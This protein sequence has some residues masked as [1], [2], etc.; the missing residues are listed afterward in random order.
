MRVLIFFIIIIFN[1][2]FYS[3][4]LQNFSVF[5]V[6]PNTTLIL[7]ISYSLLRSEYESSIFGFTAGLIFDLFFGQYVGFFTLIGT[8]IGFTASKPFTNLYRDSFL[9]PIVTVLVVSFF[10][11]I[12]FYTINAFVYG[13]VSFLNYLY[14]FIIPTVIYSVVVTPIIFKFISIINSLIEEREQHKR[15]V[16]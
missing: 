1:L 11:E 9:P 14:M 16:F 6:L 12:I 4:I 2:S 7:I 13:Y 8:I 5:S 10:Y 15:K 3:T